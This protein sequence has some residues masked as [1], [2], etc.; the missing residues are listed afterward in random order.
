MILDSRPISWVSMQETN[1]V[2][3]VAVSCCQLVVG[4]HAGHTRWDVE[5]FPLC[6]ASLPAVLSAVSPPS[7]LHV[8]LLHS[9]NEAEDCRHGPGLQEGDRHCPESLIRIPVVLVRYVK[10]AIEEH[11][12]NTF[13]WW[14]TFGAGL[15]SFCRLIHRFTPSARN[16][17]FR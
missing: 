5:R 6:L 16:Q 15:G 2:V 4:L 17:W 7:S 11:L 3:G 1:F 8:S 14:E 10:H 12:H 13:L 9:R